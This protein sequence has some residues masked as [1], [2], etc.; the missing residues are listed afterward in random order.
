MQQTQQSQQPRRDPYATGPLSARSADSGCSSPASAGG[1][2]SARGSPSGRYD[3]FAI[4]AA[5]PRAC[6]YD[7]CTASPAATPR[8]SDSRLRL[9]FSLVSATAKPESPPRS[10]SR[11]ADSP[12]S[13]RTPEYYH[14]PPLPRPP[15]LLP[16]VQE[17]FFILHAPGSPPPASAQAKWVRN[18]VRFGEYFS[19]TR[20]RTR[21]IFGLGESE[22]V[23]DTAEFV[24]HVPVELNPDLARDVNVTQRHFSLGYQQLPMKQQIIPLPI[25]PLEDDGE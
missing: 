17:I 20:L 8:S 12:R 7:K 15:P 13:P 11:L 18:A 3:P 1:S 5:P 22:S 2:L 6:A 23:F 24:V 10:P 16:D 25:T 9:A 21:D 14:L 19:H 4:R